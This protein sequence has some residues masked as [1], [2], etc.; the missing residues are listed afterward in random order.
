MNMWKKGLLSAAVLAVAVPGAAFA[1][2]STPAAPGPIQERIATLKDK[3]NLKLDEWKND[4]KKQARLDQFGVHKK[5]YLTLLAEKYAPDTEADWNAVF[6]ERE[7][8]VN[9]L[10]S[11]KPTAEQKEALKS[12]RQAAAEELRKEWKDGTLSKEDLKAK[13]EALKGQIN[14]YKDQ[15]TDLRGPAIENRQEIQ[16][17][18]TDAVASGNADSIRQSLASMLDEAKKEN[19]ALAAAIEKIKSASDETSGTEAPAADAA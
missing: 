9:E 15:M 11:L 14:T 19:A 4:E 16:K 1:A 3:A 17:A 7:Q 10:K 5:T 6:A 13:L 18:F 12:K 8:L 2:A